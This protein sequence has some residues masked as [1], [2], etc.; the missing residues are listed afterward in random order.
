MPEAIARPELQSRA[1]ALLADGVSKKDVAMSIGCSNKTISRWC[2]NE[3]FAAALNA[4]IERRRQRTE[5]KLQEV[6]DEQ[7]D[8]DVDSLKEELAAYHQAMVN[9]QK[10]RLVRGREMMEKAMRRLRDLPDE[11]LTAADAVRLA[12]AGDSLLEKG[13]G[14]WGEA[15]AIDDILQRLSHA[16]Q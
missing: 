12:Q 11:A 14:N 13:M 10:Q 3:D 4:E 8:R 9:V 7:I 2:Q 15:L 6:A 5:A 16:E 1:I